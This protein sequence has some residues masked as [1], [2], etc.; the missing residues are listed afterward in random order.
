MS[1]WLTI[2]SARP[3]EEAE[4][5]LKLWKERGYK[6][7]IFRDLKTLDD[8]SRW[9]DVV[10]CVSYDTPYP[11]YAQVVN[12]MI[13]V[14][15]MH[16]PAAEWFV[17]GGDDTEPD[18]NHTAEEIA[19]QCSNYFCQSPRLSKV[20]IASPELNPMGFSGL[21]PGPAYRTFGVM[22]PTGDRFSEGSIDRICGSP[23]IGR[24]FALRTYGGN[25]PY[26]P[27]YKHM[28]VDEEL[29]EVALKLGV[30][31]QRR[32]L[33]HLHHHYTRIEGT[34]KGHEAPVPEHLKKWSTLGHW[35]E[36]K[37]IFDERKAKG[38]PGHEVI[39]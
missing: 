31:W 18:L 29:Q 20:S 15:I 38:F 7:A 1:I 8:P 12:R 13:R 39:G 11:G 24:E 10:N 32:D 3:F 2:P 17:T 19:R 21:H 34:D 25:G 9:R 30:L 26:W 35:K 5:V 33:V 37:A 22:Q 4:P 14:T 6:I 16:D 23:W 28:F 27:E 36:S